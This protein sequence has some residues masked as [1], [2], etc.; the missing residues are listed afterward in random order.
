[1]GG[2]TNADLDVQKFIPTASPYGIFTVDSSAIP[3][4]LEISGGLILNFSKEPLVL[5][6][7]DDPEN[8]RALVDNQL[9]ADLLFSVGLFD[10]LE[11]ALGLPIYFINTADI[12]NVQEIEGATTG[13]LR[14]RAKYSFLNSK[15]EP[16]GVSALAHI[17]FPT[18]DKAAF[19][20]AGQYF[21]RP[22]VVVDTRVRRLL[23]AA[24]LLVN[25]QQERGFGNLNVGSEFLYSLG[26]EY[27]IV[28]ERFLMGVEAYGSTP[29]S[30][31]FEEQSAPLEGLVGAKLRTDVGIHFQLGA[32]TGIVAGYGA[33]AYRVFGGVSYA[34]FDDDWDDDGL[35]ND[36]DQCPRDPE[37]ID[38]FEDEDGC[39]DLDNDKDGILDTDDQCPLEPED[40]DQFEDADGCPDPDNDKDAI[41]DVSDECPNDPED[42]DG[43]ED[44]DGCPDP[45]NDKDGVLDPDD[46]CVNVPGPAENKGCPYGDKDS[47]GIPDNTDKCPTVP[48][49]K[50]GFEDE[51]G[52]PDNDN[53]KDGIPDN[54]DECPNEAGVAKFKGCPDSVVVT[55]TNIVILEQIFFDV[56]KATIKPQSYGILDKV[57]ATMKKRTEIKFVEVQGHTDDTNTESYNLKL[58][59][60]RAAAVKN[61]LIKAGV[62]PERLTSKGYGETTPK[63]AFPPDLAQM[64]E[65]AERNKKKA[66]FTAAQ[67]KDVEY[68]R[69]QNRRVQFVIQNDVPGIQPE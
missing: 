48:E 20:S 25:L 28:P 46:A 17:G 45:D 26:A 40:K 50:D 54:A 9:A 15:E 67:K 43:F 23:L 24:N 61:Y 30:D 36:V 68:I 31:P 41:P 56:D 37:D 55:P 8:R 62:T 49:D 12:P 51:D 10:R 35:K 34:N 57:A 13:D 1:V 18:G 59:N 58:S 38:L 2:A 19:T 60:D 7:V 63:I 3:A 39:P 5:Q 4:E 22:G 53:D 66:N 6:A 29:F 64:L 52:C 21:I 47:D 65:T 11:L 69:S 16:V 27:E 42:K 14:L 32:G 44:E 33:P